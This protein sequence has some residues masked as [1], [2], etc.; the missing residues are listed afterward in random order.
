MLDRTSCP[1]SAVRAIKRRI[2][3]PR[4]G[5]L[6]FLAIPIARFFLRELHCVIDD[7]SWPQGPDDPK[8]QTGDAVVDIGTYSFQ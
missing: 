8:A 1:K 3:T 5:S 4:A 2:F 6:P 7:G